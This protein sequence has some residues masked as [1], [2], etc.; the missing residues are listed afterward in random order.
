VKYDA[1]AEQ[2]K[3]NAKGAKLIALNEFSSGWILF[4]STG[5]ITS[6][7]I[8]ILS[9]HFLYTL[10][11]FPNRKMRAIGLVSKFIL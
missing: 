2:K 3:S 11:F 6:N 7:C 10:P 1:L 9:S 5:R 4:L 8:Y